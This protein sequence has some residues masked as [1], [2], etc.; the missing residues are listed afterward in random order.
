MNHYA[1]TPAELPAYGHFVLW[2]YSNAGIVLTLSL[3]YF[4]FYVFFVYLCLTTEQG[5]DRLTWLHVIIFVPFFGIVLFLA[6]SLRRL[7][8]QT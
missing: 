1:I 8:R 5:I 7:S 6:H 2:L 3:L 4:A